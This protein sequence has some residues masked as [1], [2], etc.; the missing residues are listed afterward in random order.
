V[1]LSN[2][3]T[4]QIKVT[5]TAVSWY[6]SV[7][8]QCHVDIHIQH[9][10]ISY[11]NGNDRKVLGRLGPLLVFKCTA[12]IDCWQLRTSRDNDKSP[13]TVNFF[14]SFSVYMYHFGNVI[15]WSSIMAVSRV[16]ATCF[17]KRTVGLSSDITYHTYRSSSVNR[18]P[19]V[20]RIWRIYRINRSHNT[21]CIYPSIRWM[22][23]HTDAVLEAF[24][25]Q[26]RRK[27][28]NFVVSICLSALEQLLFC[29]KNFSWNFTFRSYTGY[30]CFLLRE[31]DYYYYYY[32][33]YYW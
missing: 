25:K 10:F 18:S 5:I 31:R 28:I 15:W 16:K 8:D 21:N 9:F 17:L 23:G 12:V 14:I 13:R 11:V 33:Y 26:S 22:R 19:L 3:S 1:I 4:V 30:T 2:Y 24:T 6:C 32:Y 20:V 29:R 27:I 7:L